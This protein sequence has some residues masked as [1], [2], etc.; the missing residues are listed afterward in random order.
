MSIPFC[1]AATLVRG[2][3]SMQM[4]TTYDDAEVNALVERVTLVS[5]EGVPTLCCRIEIEMADGRRIER[6]ERKTPADFSFDRATVSALVRRI[7]AET[8][9][10]ASAY[11]RLERFVDELPGGDIG[12]VVRSFAEAP[13]M[14]HAA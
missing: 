14:Q 11:D 3:P 9:V 1:I 12:A 2:T 8:G 7:G 5:D 10:P 4:M 6:H 13:R